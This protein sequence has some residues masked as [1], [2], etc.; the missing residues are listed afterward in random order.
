MSNQRNSYLVVAGLL[1]CA[2]ACGEDLAVE[3]PEP[4]NMSAL[5]TAYE[6]PSA[7]LT[8]ETADEVVTS[9]L[10]L[11]E[12]VE[13]MGGITEILE[14]LASTSGEEEQTAD[15]SLTA[16]DQLGVVTQSLTFGDISVTGEGF[17]RITRICN[18]WGESPPISMADNGYMNLTTIFSDSGLNPVIWGQMAACKYEAESNRILIESGVNLYIAGLSDITNI[19]SQPI[20]VQ[21]TGQL[22]ANDVELSIPA[23][24]RTLSDGVIEIR[25]PVGAGNVIFFSGES[26]M[27]FRAANGTFT[28]DL[29]NNECQNEE[30]PSISW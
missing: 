7:D 22:E 11:L 1:L 3:M 13:T 18:G 5:V 17:M 26:G 24:F 23:D 21:L 2:P 8:A 10:E 12:S 25:L 9:A 14:A 30:G 15:Q 19:E 16:E 4:P 20:L 29:T 27:G 28:C 6:T